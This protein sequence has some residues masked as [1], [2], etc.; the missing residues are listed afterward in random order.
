[1]SRGKFLSLEEARQSGDFKQFC[2]EHPAKADR[3]R[4]LKLLSA[5]S[6][7]ALEEGETSSPDR[8]GDSTGTRTQRD[9]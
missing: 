3:D 1:M 2:K 8:D 4:F 7:G 5:M 6:L 9:T